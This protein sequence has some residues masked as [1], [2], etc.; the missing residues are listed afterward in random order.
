MSGVRLLVG[1]RKGA[2]ILTSDG[3][4][5]NWDVS[6]PHFGGWEMYHL[7]GSPADPNRIYASQI[8]RLVRPDDAAVERWR[9]ELGSRSATS[10]ST[11]ACPARTS[12]TTARRT[13][14]SSSASGISSRR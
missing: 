3:T 13:R 12:G 14:G 4:R 11:T 2:F 9:Q 10:S 5:K 1:T 6:G 7:K 8:V